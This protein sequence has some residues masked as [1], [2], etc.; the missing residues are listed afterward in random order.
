MGNDGAQ[1]QAE[2]ERFSMEEREEEMDKGE[3]DAKRQQGEEGGPGQLATGGSGW[4]GD[5]ESDGECTA[6]DVSMQGTLTWLNE[7]TCC[8]SGVHL[9]CAFV[10]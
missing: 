10:S 6:R 8:D 5:T 4:E 9:C 7:V 2:A 1:S 3:R